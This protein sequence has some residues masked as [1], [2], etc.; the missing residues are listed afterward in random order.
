MNLKSIREAKANKTAEARAIL[1]KAEG[2]NRNLTAEEAAKFDGLKAEIEA[3]ESQEARQQFLEEAERRMAGTVVAGERG[4]DLEQLES[5]VSLQRILQAGMEGRALDGAEAE[6]NREMERRNGRKAQGFYVPMSLLET[7]VNTTTSAAD[8]V[9]TD[10]RADQ[11]IGPLRDALLARRLGVRVLSGL[12]G[13]V[14]IP[15]HGSSV[16]TGWVAENSALNASDMTFGKVT[17]SPKHAGC[18]SEMSRQLI[19]QSDPSIE[20][21]LRDDLAF[22]IAKAIDAALIH[23]GGT[24]EPDGVTA[25]LGTANGTLAGPTWAQVLEI[26]EAVETAN[27]LGSHSWLMNPAAKAKLRET[28]KVT[29]DAGAGFLL[30]NGQL[31]GYAVHTTNQAG[32]TSNGNNVIFGDWSQVLLGVWS[33]LDILV[34]PY[35]STAYARGGVM[36]RAMATVDVAIRHP[37][38]FVWVDDVP[39]L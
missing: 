12:R 11:Y 21:L 39:S 31:G 13:D 26:I 37:E 33:E 9:G 30:E 32:S 5:R 15:K 35:E 29:G 27:A 18:L 6:Y 16:V 7:R 8:L 22:N 20:R 36:V 23:G 4:N 3:L 10:H 38:A 2:E 28:L 25:T 17:L 34:N 19:Q 14:S 1:A 24:N